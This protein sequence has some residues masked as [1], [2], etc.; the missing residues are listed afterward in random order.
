VFSHVVKLNPNDPAASPI[1]ARIN[2]LFAV[3]AEARE[4]GLS[5][6]ARHRL[7]QQKAPELLEKIKAAI[8]AAKPGA[9][10]RIGPEKLDPHWQSGSGPENSRD[11]IGD[12]NLSPAEN[13]GTRL[14]IGSSPRPRQ[15]THASSA[16]PHPNRLGRSASVEKQNSYSSRMCLH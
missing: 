2:E 12:R 1:V 8:E 14:F 3:D 10:D 6:E 16:R 9:P 11:P 7:R 4:Q 13:L 15:R 5:V